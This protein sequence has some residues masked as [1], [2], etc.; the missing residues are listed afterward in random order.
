MGERLLAAVHRHW[1]VL[2]FAAVV[3]VDQATKGLAGHGHLGGDEWSGG[4]MINPAAGSTVPDP[5]HDLWAQPVLGA[6]LDLAS[7]SRQSSLSISF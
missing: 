1:A 3:V 4:Y 6:V 5:L 2:L 7:I